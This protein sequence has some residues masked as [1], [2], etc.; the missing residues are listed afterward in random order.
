MKNKT[1]RPGAVGALLDL[2]ER[3]I[4]DLI[5]LAEKIPPEEYTAVLD[6]ETKDEECR[7]VQTILS[8]VVGS[9][10]G[11]ADYIK[12]AF[13][14]A[15]RRPET[16]PVT[17][18]TAAALLIGMM[19]YTLTTIEP[20]CTYPYE[21]FDGISIDTRWGQVYDFEQLME[22]AIVHVSRHH[23]QIERLREART[24]SD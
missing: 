2:Y 9:G 20:M 11:Y 21:R 7:S 24:T 12:T 18:E 14:I 1:Y 3:A 17:R 22:H 10:Y 23:R 5:G 13:E 16:E 15:G 19:K 6:A 4:L 8:H